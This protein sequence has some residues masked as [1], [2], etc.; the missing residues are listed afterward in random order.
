MLVTQNLKICI[1]SVSSDI[2]YT[3][4]LSML[5]SSAAVGNL[6]QSKRLKKEEGKNLGFTSPFKEVNL[7][8]T[9]MGGVSFQQRGV[10]LLLQ[11]AQAHC[12]T[13]SCKGKKTER[14]VFSY[15]LI[16]FMHV[17]AQIFFFNI[18]CGTSRHKISSL[19]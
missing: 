17:L 8:P 6:T 10:L 1:S 13:C 11:M 3:N 19:N 9:W 5:M 15:A 14:C 18:T 7:L 12:L 16:Y 2:Y 4:N